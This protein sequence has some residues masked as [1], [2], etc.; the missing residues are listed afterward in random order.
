M[1]RHKTTIVGAVTFV[2]VMVLFT[3]AAWAEQTLVYGSAEG[4]IVR[5]DGTSSAHD[6]TVTG[7]QIDGTIEFKVALP[8]G[9]TKEQIK[10][11]LVARPKAVAQVAIPSRTLKSGKKDMDKKM[12]DALRA[13]KHPEIAYKL[14]DIEVVGDG[15]SNGTSFELRATGALTIAGTTRTLEMPMTIEVVDQRH[16]RISGRTAIKMSDYKVE[17]PQALG[18]LIKAGDKVVVDVAWIVA[19]AERP[20]AVAKE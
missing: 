3:A 10:Q 11:A 15:G 7:R 12:I 2:A 17:R 18:G 20:V 6:W 4:S 5:V 1:R 13:K 14:V 9:A 19:S 8:A 16:L